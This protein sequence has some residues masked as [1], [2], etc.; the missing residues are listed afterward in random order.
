MGTSIGHILLIFWL[1]ITAGRSEPLSINDPV[2]SDGK[3]LQALLDLRDILKVQDTVWHQK[4]NP[5]SE[6]PGISCEN[7]HVVSLSLSSI[8]YMGSLQD[9]SPMLESTVHAL[10]QLSFLRSFNATGFE[11]RGH[12][13]ESIGKLNKLN[14]LDLTRTALYGALPASLKLLTRL[15]FLSLAENNFTGS[16]SPSV[17][18][19]CNL[20][21]FNLSYNS[22]TRS[23]PFIL[24]SRAFQLI[25]IDLSHNKF[26]NQIPPFIGKL[27]NLCHLALGHNNLQGNLPIKHLNFSRLEYLDVSVNNLEGPIAESIS[28]MTSLTYLNLEHNYFIGSIPSAITNC[29]R[30]QTLILDRN[31]LTN[32]LP[33]SVAT[34]SNLVILSLSFNNL[35]GSIPSRIFTLPKLTTLVLSH[36]LFFGQIPFEKLRPRAM[37]VLDLSYN[38]LQGD[39]VKNLYP[40]E[41]VVKNCFLGAPNQHAPK[42]CRQFYKKVGI[43]WHEM[44]PKT[45]L[46]NGNS[47]SPS[48]GHGH[49]HKI[50]WLLIILGCAAGGAFVLAIAGACAVCNERYKDDLEPEINGEEGETYTERGSSLNNILRL[51]TFCSFLGESFSYDRL[52]RATS[53]FSSSQMLANGHS[54]EFYK[55]TL[56][57]GTVVVVKRVYTAKK[58]ELYFKELE[59]LQKTSHRRLITVVGHCMDT[60]EEKFLVY[61]YMPCGDLASLLQ[62]KKTITEGAFH[63]CQRPLDW[64]TRLK[65]AIG[66]AEGLTYLHHECSPPIVHGNVKATSILLDEKFEVKLC[67]LSSAR[68]EDKASHPKLISCLLGLSR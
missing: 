44:P 11:F 22:F 47:I 48:L 4:K 38:F 62:M 31:M 1:G 49:T 32:N 63:R 25:Y 15:E 29:S 16:V 13:P 26:E 39:P 51:H 24:F 66:V 43:A 20:K 37:Q 21:H 46:P 40:V 36:N 45:V 53:G 61:K 55:G 10:S 33:P 30:L 42:A 35:S 8:S 54:G 67:S 9:S 56:G 52:H 18:A 41:N 64:I 60:P 59:I 65:I 12:L 3:E 14:T 28:H 6:W 17:D 34:L 19:L 27:V 7:G 57:E 2:N 68:T 23:L 50:K 5:C 58:L